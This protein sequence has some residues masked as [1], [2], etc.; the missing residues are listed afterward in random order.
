MHR[1]LLQYEVIRYRKKENIEQGIAAATS[2]I[3]KSLLVDEA[4]KRFM[5]E[6]N[7]FQNDMS[8]FAKHSVIL[9]K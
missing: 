5:K 2:Q 6:I 7:N 4:G 8:G 1:L 9:Q 3:T